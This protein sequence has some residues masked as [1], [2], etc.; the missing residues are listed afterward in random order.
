MEKIINNLQNL[1]TDAVLIIGDKTLEI[2]NN[3]YNLKL[4]EAFKILVDKVYYNLS[5]LNNY[6]YKLE[7]IQGFF[8]SAK[9]GLSPTNAQIEIFNYINSRSQNYFSKWH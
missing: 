9:K 6:K 8:Y 3:N 4:K 2:K 5:I 1:I 7:D